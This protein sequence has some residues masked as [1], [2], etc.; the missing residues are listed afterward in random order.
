MEK[1]VSF[2][3]F[4]MGEIT[5]IHL[6]ENGFGLKLEPVWKIS[7]FKLMCSWSQVSLGYV[8]VY[9]YFQV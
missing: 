6:T 9:L 8:D 3:I 1:C 5:T 4:L 7:L 2:L